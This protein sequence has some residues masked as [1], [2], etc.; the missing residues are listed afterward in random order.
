MKD[1]T[2]QGFRERK[3]DI[4]AQRFREKKIGGY[5]LNE[6]EIEREILVVS[7]LEREREREIGSYEFMKEKRNWRFMVQREINIWGCGFREIRV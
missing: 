3:R 4:E 1:I 5:G 6:R 2:R 7:G